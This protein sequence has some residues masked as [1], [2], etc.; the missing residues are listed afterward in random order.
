MP[1]FP[2]TSRELARFLSKVHPADANG[3]KLWHG[4]FDRHGYGR[5]WYRGRNWSAHRVALELAAGPPPFP[6]AVA[7]H[8]PVVCHNRAC[9]ASEHLRWAT[10]TVNQRDRVT[11]D[12]H[13]RGE[14]S[15]TAKLTEAQ[16]VHLR[17]EYAGGG[18]QQQ[19]LAAR[20]GVSRGAI[21][22]A[23]LRK[24]WAHS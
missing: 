23:I 3:C 8:R 7:S 12:T 17:A 21:S 18:V 1:D 4:W 22:R 6:E 15:G 11:D 19:E 9:V 5:F 20:Y 16:V 24:T 10:V 13:S 14:R 2:P